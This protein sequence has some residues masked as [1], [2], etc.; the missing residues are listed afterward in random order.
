MFRALRVN[1]VVA[2][3]LKRASHRQVERWE[4]VRMREERYMVWGRGRGWGGLRQGSLHRIY[5]FAV[6]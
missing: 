3:D 2:S 5:A 1:T 4:P 6:G